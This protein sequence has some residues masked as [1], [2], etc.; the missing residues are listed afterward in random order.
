MAG[1]MGRRGEGDMP[2]RPHHE[3]GGRPRASY[4]STLV[5]TFRTSDMIMLC[6]TVPTSAEGQAAGRTRRPRQAP[7]ALASLD[8]EGRKVRTV[9][10]PLGSPPSW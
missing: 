7:P 4:L 5:S 9:P 2:R 8:D 3:R 10:E 6:T 1:N